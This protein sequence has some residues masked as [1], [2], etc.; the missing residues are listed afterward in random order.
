MIVYR[1]LLLQLRLTC[2]L[3]T[4]GVLSVTREDAL[5]YSEQVDV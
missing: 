2:T 3:D 4:E 1:C 5:A